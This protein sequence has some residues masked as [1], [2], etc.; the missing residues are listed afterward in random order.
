MTSNLVKGLI[1]IGALSAAGAG[2]AAA[3][4]HNMPAPGLANA[5]VIANYINPLQRGSSFTE[6]QIGLTG[7]GKVT[8]EAAMPTVNEWI[9]YVKTNKDFIRQFPD[10][11]FRDNL[12]ETYQKIEKKILKMNKGISPEEYNRTLENLTSDW[13][14]GKI[15][16]K[17]S[18]N[19]GNGVVAF[20]KRGKD[21]YSESGLWYFTNSNEKSS[22]VF[23]PSPYVFREGFSKA[24]IES[25]IRQTAEQTAKQ[26]VADYIA[27]HKKMEKLLHATGPEARK[28]GETLDTVYTI[29][30]MKNLRKKMGTKYSSHPSTGVPTKYKLPKRRE[31]LRMLS[32]I[33]YSGYENTAYVTTGLRIGGDNDF[34][35]VSVDGNIGWGFSKNN[36][37]TIGPTSPVGFYGVGKTKLSGFS[38]YGA[39]VNLYL[40][41]KVKGV[42]GLGL[43]GVSYDETQTA[44]IMKGNQVLSSNS[45]APQRRYDSLL[46]T[47]AGIDFPVAVDIKGS[48][49]EI[50]GTLDYS[51]NEKKFFPGIVGKVTF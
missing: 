1:F 26:T 34:V 18:E 8:A 12:V 38:T 3:E 32:G 30:E 37:E 27:E 11:V 17:E 49:M 46:R 23:V 10:A 13:S 47:L 2:A 20:V 36:S 35:N 50:D 45:A 44:Q 21:P 5:M 33:G 16:V 9:T 42:I 28:K 6:D 14:D 15:T 7:E 43:E 22:K 48:R 4:S 24:Q 39:D 19:A 41:N 29:E 51:L 25:F 31:L 40:G